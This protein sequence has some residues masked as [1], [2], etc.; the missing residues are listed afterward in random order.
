MTPSCDDFERVGRAEYL[1]LREAGLFGEEW[2]LEWLGDARQV[3][4]LRRAVLHSG[5]KIEMTEGDENHG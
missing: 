3:P 2:R 4:P 1:H 5:R